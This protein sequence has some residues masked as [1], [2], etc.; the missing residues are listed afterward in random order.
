MT[1]I[2]LRNVREANRSSVLRTVHEY[3]RISRTELAQK[4]NLSL[5][6]VSRIVK[7]LAADG[8]LVETGYGSSSG[9]RKPVIIEANPEAGT[10]L[11]VDCAR[12]A[13]R[14]AAFDFAGDMI[15][16]ASYPINQ[17]NYLDAVLETCDT[18]M[19][20]QFPRILGL[21]VGVR[22]LIDV[23]AGVI[24]SSRNFRETDI[25]L[26]YILEQR[27]GVPVLLN[28]SARFAALAEWK[29]TYQQ[30]IHNMVYLTTNWGLG[31]GII[32]EDNIFCGAHGAFGEVG[33]ILIPQ[34]EGFCS[35]ESLCG[36][37][38]LVHGA[39]ERWDTP[40]AA[41]LRALAASVDELSPQ[42][43]AKCASE[44][45]SLCAELVHRALRFLGMGIVSIANTFDPELIVVGGV[46]SETG[47]AFLP[48]LREMLDSSLPA[49]IASKIRLET[50]ELGDDAALLGASTMLFRIAFQPIPERNG[51]LSVTL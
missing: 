9:G 26:R 28:M 22:G 10:F 43:V 36:G 38:A 8:Y 12:S 49:A 32:L 46:M 39:A 45:D 44:G 4:L 51:E 15:S 41:G 48:T 21:A 3:R 31:S 20:Q 5:P 29:L 42:I 33:E 19:S 18:C 6:A 34:G 17:R 30:Q 50:S 1:G 14:T 11:C 16:S 40:E 25:P 2:D 24:R 13:I 37:Q 23:N 35:L 7:E 27:Y 47:E